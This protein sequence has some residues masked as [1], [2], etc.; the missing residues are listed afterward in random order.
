VKEE[1]ADRQTDPGAACGGHAQVGDRSRSAGKA[2]DQRDGQLADVF[3]QWHVAAAERF[4]HG[5]PAD[6]G[7]DLPPAA[8][9]DVLVPPD[10]R[11][12]PA[13]S[14]AAAKRPIVN[15]LDRARGLVL[16]AGCGPDPAPVSGL[17][18]GSAR[19]I[20]AMDTDLGTARAASEAARR[21]GLSTPAVVADGEQL[22][23][24][25]GAFDALA[26]EQAIERSA[27]DKACVR[28]LARVLR[29]GGRAVF[30]VA[31]RADAL[32][33]QR[34]VRDRLRGLN[35]PPRAYFHGDRH[36][37]EYT[38]GEFERLVGLAFGV[39]RRHAVGWNGG[40]KG[41]IASLLVLVPPLRFFSQVMVLETERRLMPASD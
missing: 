39:R 30:A 27:N 15:F 24:R 19:M 34:R 21:A 40:R 28:E 31:N 5:R 10:A 8:G 35:R 6:R 2:P 3:A 12:A 22:P 41:R 33:V 23:F 32:V 38:W 26:C 36:L 18:S 37:R 25:R 29:P 17:A 16:A 13:S 7:L 20:V 14:A 9:P 1:C 11:D 4:V